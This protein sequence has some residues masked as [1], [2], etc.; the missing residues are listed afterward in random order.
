MPKKIMEPFDEKDTRVLL[1]LVEKEECEHEEIEDRC[2]TEC[3]E[4][5]EMRYNWEHDS[6]DMER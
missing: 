2:C 4:M 5:I 1:R 6:R 3:G